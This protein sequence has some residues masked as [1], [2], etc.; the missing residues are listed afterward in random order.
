[1]ANPDEFLDDGREREQNLSLKKAVRILRSFSH[2]SPE[3]TLAD[4]VRR[5]GLART[6]CYRLVSTLEQ[7]GLLDRDPDT[8]R[9]RI[10]IALFQLGGIA[11]SGVTIRSA[12]AAAL[13]DLCRQTGDTV[14]LVIEHGADALCIDRFDGDYPIQQT[15]LTMGKTMP[16]HVGGGPFA[17]FSHMPE[18]RREAI[19]RKPLQAATRS[20][21][22]DVKQIRKRME[23]VRRVGFSVGD[24]DA[25]EYLLA[26]GV[27]IFGSLGRV[28]G[29]LSV[30]GLKQRYPKHRIAEVA[31]LAVEAGAKISARL[32]GSSSASAVRSA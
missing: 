12:S 23:H 31:K 18:E 6:V 20:T 29:A 27:P 19:L 30:G 8:S 7:E 4:I 2:S 13:S 26:I 5:T 11:L 9:Y 24:E 15:A 14:L 3:L 21:V 22:T 32:N 1:M 25:I 16:L 10:A 28:I 17:L